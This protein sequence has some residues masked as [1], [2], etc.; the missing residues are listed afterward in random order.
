M[1]RMGRSFRECKVGEIMEKWKFPYV[2][3]VEIFI[4]AVGI[5]EALLE[6]DRLLEYIDHETLRIEL[7][8]KDDR[9]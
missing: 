9:S 4:K 1:S 3:N 8:D 6:C 2:I 5:T 7:M